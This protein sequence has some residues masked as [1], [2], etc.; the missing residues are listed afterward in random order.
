MA[1]PATRGH[2]RLPG[3]NRPGDAGE[4]PRP[5]VGVSAYVEVAGWGVW[6]RPTHLLPTTYAEAL[7]AAGACPVILPPA[8]DPAGVVR[9]LDGVIIAGGPDVSPALYGSY[10]HA[11]TVAADPVRDEWEQGLVHAAVAE[12]KPLLGIC[13]GMQLLNVALGG[14]LVQ[15]LPDVVGS[16]L[17]ASAPG[18]FSGHTVHIRDGS[19]CRMTFGSREVEV[20][21]HHHQAVDRLADPF[22]VSAVADDGVVEAIEAALPAPVIGVQWH[23]EEQRDGPLLQRFVVDCRSACAVV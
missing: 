19:W 8:G 10:P 17:H 7:L 9:R 2:S 14:T 16:D 23:P 6:Q 21:T 11:R 12:R 13:R 22:A 15:H 18:E 3:G 5:I 20:Q 1:E 4:P